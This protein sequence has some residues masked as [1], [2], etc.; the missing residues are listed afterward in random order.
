MFAA[1]YPEIRRI[2][3]AAIPLRMEMIDVQIESGAAGLAGAKIFELAARA[4]V[5]ND[6]SPL[7]RDGIP[8]RLWFEQDRQRN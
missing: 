4:L 2:V 7:W 5:Q 6:L 3:G 1:K 8:F